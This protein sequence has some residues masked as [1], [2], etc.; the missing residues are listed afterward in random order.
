[1]PAVEEDTGG[2]SSSSKGW[3]CFPK[4]DGG[5]ERMWGWSSACIYNRQLCKETEVEK[6]KRKG[7]DRESK[8]REKIGGGEK[9]EREL[10]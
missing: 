1:V 4:T 9:K 2:A 5:D 10:A 7:R 3:D 8:Y 6:K